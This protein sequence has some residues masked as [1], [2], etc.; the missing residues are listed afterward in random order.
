MLHGGN[1]FHN[2]TL[3]GEK[4][5][6]ALILVHHEDYESSRSAFERADHNTHGINVKFVLLLIGIPAKNRSKC[7]ILRN[8]GTR[9]WALFHPG[10]V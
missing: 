10:A 6:G 7:H 5:L 9:E 4:S 8:I 3:R 1:V 2:G